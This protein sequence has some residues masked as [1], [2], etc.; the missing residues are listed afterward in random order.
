VAGIC[1]DGGVKPCYWKN[2][3]RFILNS[4]ASATSS[5]N[6]IQLADGKVHIAGTDATSEARYWVYDASTNAYISDESLFGGTTA[7]SISIPQS[8][9]IYIAGTTGTKAVYWHNGAP[10]VL[11]GGT[12]AYSIVVK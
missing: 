8:G 4:T 10:V 5:A 1:D 6:C 3:S 11:T 7:F 9:D 2:G 12:K